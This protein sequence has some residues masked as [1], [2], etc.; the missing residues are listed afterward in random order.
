MSTEQSKSSE[1]SHEQRARLCAARMQHLVGYAEKLMHRRAQAHARPHPLAN[2]CWLRAR[3]SSHRRPRMRH[4]LQRILRA[5]RPMHTE[6]MH[7]C[8]LAEAN[9][10]TQQACSLLPARVRARLT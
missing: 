4:A 2:T 8:T 1:R 3:P 6:C 7:T 10:D 5:C 9:R